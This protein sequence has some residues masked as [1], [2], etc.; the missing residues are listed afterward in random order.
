MGYYESSK[1]LCPENHYSQYL[2]RLSG[3]ILITVMLY[4]TSFNNT[5]HQKMGSIQ[6]DAAVVITDAIR[7]S[8]REKLYHELGLESLQQ[9]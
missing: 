8:S 2:N 5:F 1:T 6:Y 9:R 7:G 3:L 4:M